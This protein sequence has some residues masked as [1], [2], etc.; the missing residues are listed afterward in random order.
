MTDFLIKSTIAMAVLLALYHLLFEREKMHRFNRFYLIGM[1]VFSLTL[2]LIAI[3]LYVK[4]VTEPQP[5]VME[6]QLEFREQQMPG[7]DAHSAPALPVKKS[8]EL[9][10]EKPQVN[11]LPYIGWAFY[12]LVTAFLA[13]RFGRNI[14]RFYRLKRNNTIVNYKGINLVLLYDDVLPY[15]F[16]GTI[17]MSRGDYENRDITPELFTHEL[18]HVKQFHSID[19]L[20]IEMLK[21]IFWFNPLLYFYKKAIQLNHEFLADEKVI[22]TTANTV[23]YQQ[24]LLEKASVG[25]TFS[26]AS[27]LNFSLTKKRFIMMTKTTNQTKGLLL[28]IAVLPVSVGLLYFLST[29]T[30]V[31]AKTNDFIPPA[32][33]VQPEITTSTFE[34]TS[35]TSQ[36][37]TKQQV[38]ATKTVKVNQTDTEARKNEY[39]KGVRIIIEDAQ[40]GKYVDLPYERLTAE[41]RQYYLPQAP[42]KRKGVG[43]SDVDYDYSLNKLY[44]EQ[45]GIFFLDDIKISRDEILKHKKEDFATYAAKSTGMAVVDGKLKGN[46][47]SYFYTY[48]YFNKYLKHSNDHYPD[49][50]LKITITE[51]PLDVWLGHDFNS[52]EKDGLKNDLERLEAREKKENEATFYPTVEEI[53]K[54]QRSFYPRFPQGSDKFDEYL[55]NNI[56]LDDKLKD[57]QLSINF[58]VNTDGTLSQPMILGEKDEEIISEIIKVIENSSIWIPAQDNGK[59]YKVGVSVNYP[60]KPSK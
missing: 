6:Q 52:K 32:V 11:F 60:P 30:V 51:K 54:R 43:V 15:T 37:S 45:G 10:A 47:F 21:T 12:I 19:I 50:S 42:E 13:L 38:L 46:N 40:K 22:N 57:R 35:E 41:D 1:L 59:P 17:Y 29:E 18:A 55:A 7:T 3:P 27:N 2:P 49:K 39:Y 58:T 56:K 34:I 24:L 36:D 16:L 28:K 33:I 23:Y 44:N 25:K 14:V 4:A 5:M 8:F 9:K 48:E 53:K 26:I 20:F 31:L